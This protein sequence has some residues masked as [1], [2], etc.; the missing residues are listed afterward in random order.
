MDGY[1]CTAY[2]KRTTKD[3]TTDVSTEAFNRVTNIQD[4]YRDRAK[5]TT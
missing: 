4:A 1:W 5:T 2:G 3:D